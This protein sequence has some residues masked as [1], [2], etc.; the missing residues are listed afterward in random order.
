MYL[1]LMQFSVTTNVMGFRNRLSD[2]AALCHADGGR[3][4]QARRPPQEITPNAT[5]KP[6]VDYQDA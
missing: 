1:H 6:S 2:G 3:V 5:S 4:N